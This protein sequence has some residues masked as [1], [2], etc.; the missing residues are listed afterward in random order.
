[1]GVPKARR[2]ILS[3]TSNGPN[4]TALVG[5]QN[6]KI[7]KLVISICRLLEMVVLGSVGGGLGSFGWWL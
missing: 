2:S 7:W 6:P 4:S 1:M 5:K 3:V